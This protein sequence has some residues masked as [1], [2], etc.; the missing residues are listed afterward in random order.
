MMKIESPKWRCAAVGCNAVIPS[1]TLFCAKHAAMLNTLPDPIR[2]G[3]KAACSS[4]SDAALHA[5]EQARHKMAVREGL[6]EP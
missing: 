5:L 6:R 1:R 2:N 3:V 4:R